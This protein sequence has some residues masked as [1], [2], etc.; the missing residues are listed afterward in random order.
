[1]DKLKCLLTIENLGVR[2]FGDAKAF[3]CI[4]S[5]GSEGSRPHVWVVASGCS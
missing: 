2:N 5:A 4:S 3:L 1:M